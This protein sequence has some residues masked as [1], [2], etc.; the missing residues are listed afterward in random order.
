MVRPMSL[1]NDLNRFLR[2]LEGAGYQV[3]KARTRNSYKILRGG[4]L[5]TVL[6]ASPTSQQV[7]TDARRNVRKYE[8]RSMG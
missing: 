1:P 8:Q 2:E 7:L 3:T 4:Y 5:V 6:S